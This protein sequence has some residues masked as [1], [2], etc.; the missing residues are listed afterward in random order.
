MRYQ[1]G[2]V[3]WQKVL[4]TKHF[5]QAEDSETCALSGGRKLFSKV[6]APEEGNRFT[7]TGTARWSVLSGL[8]KI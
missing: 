2:R 1:R 6:N 8:R 4:T 7:G 3:N 5:A